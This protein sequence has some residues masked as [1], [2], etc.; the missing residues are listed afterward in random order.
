M[1]FTELA[2]KRFSVRKYSDK[3]V[4]KEVLDQILDAGMLAPTAKN[5]QPQ[6]IYVL[7]SED[8]FAKLDALTHCRYGAQTVLLFAYNADED[9]K[10]PNE[11][12]VHS[13]IEDVSIVATHMMLR[14]AELGVDTTWCNMFANSKLEEAFELPKNE[15]SVL[16]MPVG[17]RAEGAVPAPMH[18]ASKSIDEIVKYL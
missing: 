15:K 6:R 16:I 10:N 14:A 5:L 8:S 1:T 13:G 18:E 17:Y 3:T 11:D 4:E 7:Q 9:W 2:K 12:G